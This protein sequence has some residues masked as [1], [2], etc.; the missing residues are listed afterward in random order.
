MTL[1][2]FYMFSITTRFLSPAST[3]S[4]GNAWDYESPFSAHKRKKKK[5]KRN[6]CLFRVLAAKASSTNK[7]PMKSQSVKAC[8]YNEMWSFL[9]DETPKASCWKRRLLTYYKISNKQLLSI[10]SCV[11]FSSFCHCTSQVALFS[12]R[13]ILYFSLQDLVLFS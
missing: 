12:L 4:A 2:K 7:K 1:T 6:A 11:K 10:R 13:T 9:T 5:K 8:L 3:V